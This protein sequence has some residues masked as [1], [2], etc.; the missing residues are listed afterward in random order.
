MTFGIICF[1]FLGF[2]AVQIGAD[3]INSRRDYSIADLYSQ[4][5]AIPSK[6]SSG[7]HTI[8]FDSENISD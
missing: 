2:V 6:L 7:V 5:V 4:S 8:A 3:D 1:S